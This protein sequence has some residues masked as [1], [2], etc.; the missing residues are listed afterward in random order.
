MEAISINIYD[1][2]KST[3]SAVLQR[4]D[5][6]FSNQENGV[7]T[8]SD[9]LNVVLEPKFIEN[10]QKPS[11]HRMNAFVN[12]VFDDGTSI[13]LKTDHIPTILGRTNRLYYRFLREEV[14][15]KHME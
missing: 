9:E 8:A 12:Y 10:I 13:I 2:R 15:L 5:V 7:L 14:G 11:G 6:E 3:K 4:I 1:A